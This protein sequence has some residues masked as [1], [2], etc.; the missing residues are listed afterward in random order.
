[1]F[2]AAGLVVAGCGGPDGADD[3][4]TPPA[5]EQPAGKRVMV[6]L[7]DFRI[8]LSQETFTPGTYTFVVTNDGKAPHALDIEGPGVEEKRTETLD[9][10]Q[11]ANLTATLGAETYDFY[12]PVSNHREIGMETKVAVGGKEAPTTGGGNNGY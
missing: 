4:T 6:S 11:S 5:G 1:M 9:A 3:A 7:T 2:G 8:E 12:C 10:G